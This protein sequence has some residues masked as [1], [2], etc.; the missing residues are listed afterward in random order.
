[1]KGWR[2]NSLCQLHWQSWDEGAVLFNAASGQTHFLNE[3]GTLSLR[4]II[5]HPRD[6]DALLIALSERYEAFV[7]D[8]ELRE[9]VASTLDELDRLGLIEPVQP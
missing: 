1:M 7:I 2:V 3:L 6:L 5:Q 4:L 9:Y 8:E